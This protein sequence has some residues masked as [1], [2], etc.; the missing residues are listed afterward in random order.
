MGK[1]I[2]AILLLCS[3]SSFAQSDSSKYYG[4]KDY[5]WYYQ[6]VWPKKVLMLPSDTVNNKLG[7]AQIG[8]T[9]FIGNGSY[10]KSIQA[11]GT[12]VDSITQV[13]TIIYVWSNGASTA[14]ETKTSFTFTPNYNNKLFLLYTNGVL[15]DSV[16]SGVK[17]V[18]GIDGISVI[19]SIGN[20][21]IS[22]SG[23]GST[24]TSLI[25][26]IVSDSLAALSTPDLQKVTDAGSE[27][28]NDFG[29]STVT[30]IPKSIYVTRNDF[31]SGIYIGID[32]SD[33]SYVQWNK[34]GSINANIFDQNITVNR[35][36]QL[37]DR[38]ATLTAAVKVNGTVS[39]AD[40]TGLVDLGAISGSAARFGIEDNLGLQNRLVDMNDNRLTITAGTPDFSGAA[41]YF[42]IR[43]DYVQ[44]YV[45][46]AYTGEYTDILSRIV[47][48]GDIATEISSRDS[49]LNLIS[50]SV[51][52][53]SIIVKKDLLGVNGVNR[54]LPLSVQINGTETF[55][56][57][58]GKIDLGTISGGGG[59]SG[60]VTS[61]TA[62][63]GT[64]GGTITTSGTIGADT[65]V[66]ESQA[67]AVNRAFAAKYGLDSMYVTSDGLN[68]VFAYKSGRRDTIQLTASIW[69]LAGNALTAGQSF[70][71]ST[72]NTSMRFRTNGIER[73]VLDSTGG[74]TFPGATIGTSVINLSGASTTA[75]GGISWGSGS[76]I[77]RSGSAT[78][79]VQGSF[80]TTSNLGIVNGG[81]LINWQ[82]QNNGYIVFGSTG[83]SMFKNLSDANPAVTI[84]NVHGGAT[85]KILVLASSV[86][87]SVFSVDRYG[88]IAMDATN[89]AT[90]TT[91]AQTINK[92]SGFVNFAAGAS[93]LVVTN[94]LALTTSIVQ[95]Q[96]YG[97]DATATTA[98]VTLAAGS[99]TISLNAAATAE[100]KVSFIVFN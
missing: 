52:P 97:T 31:S 76:S 79:T 66:L 56:D 16:P 45:K 71:G 96:V 33:R 75:A 9:A 63:Y 4:S 39:T 67:R 84:T 69:G 86:G 92:P 59:G 3:V 41:S 15:T 20:F 47:S 57:A 28:T 90:G 11:G 99:F 13:G 50:F 38:D 21:Y 54:H 68:A 10:W 12:K 55:A 29:V 72:N 51:Y 34:L 83:L 26:E 19:D 22:G 78:I 65:T 95:V 81:A 36:L 37:P 77:Y 1:F 46:G 70:I 49:S 98:R 61:I 24:D 43:N 80:N 73:M 58:T 89:T 6:R 85:G 17:D 62:G 30:G 42:E 23:S 88:K 53:D 82:N 64:T 14:Y 8:S 100:T 91:G 18:Y 32:G 7:I 5:G 74:L 60:T 87:A 35:T 93:T 27:T 2:I 48:G 25:R 94:S 44:N 40:S